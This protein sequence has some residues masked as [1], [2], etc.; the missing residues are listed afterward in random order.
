MFTVL[1]ILCE[2]QQ[3]DFR[4]I[5]Q[6][7]QDVPTSGSWPQVIL[8]SHLYGIFVVGGVERERVDPISGIIPFS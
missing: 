2:E 5:L 8:A 3:Q 4:L 6:E 7:V 1:N